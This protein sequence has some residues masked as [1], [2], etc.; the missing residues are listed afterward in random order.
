MT[1][2]RDQLVLVQP[3][4]FYVRGQ[5]REGDRHVW[6]ARSRFIDEADLPAFDHTGPHGPAVPADSRAEAP[7]TPTIPVDLKARM[8]AMWP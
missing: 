5:A 3:L 8:R 1:R 2:A 6:A 7:A 4:R